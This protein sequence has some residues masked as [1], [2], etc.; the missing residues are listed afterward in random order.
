MPLKDL[1]LA[2]A[3]PASPV[4]PPGADRWATLESRIG[5]ALPG[6]YRSMAERYGCGGFGAYT[7]SGA[8]FDL[9]YAVSPGCTHSPLDALRWMKERTEDMAVIRAS[10]PLQVPSA[11]HP[12]PGGLL[13]AGGTTTL[14][15]IYWRTAG[16]PDAWTCAVCDSGCETWFEWA[17]DLT[18]LFAAIATGRVPPWIVA[19]VPSFPLVFRDPVSASR[20]GLL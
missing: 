12:E 14:H 15:S 20:T 8:F 17:G 7:E 9:L 19:G 4:D 5:C 18:S 2:C 16:A 10:Y 11:I 13:Y 6:D 1:L 3:P